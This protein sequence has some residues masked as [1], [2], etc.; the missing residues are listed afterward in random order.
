MVKAFGDVVRER[1]EKQKITLRKFADSVGMS[2]TYLSKIERGEFPP[3]A[4]EK[5]LAIAQRLE[6]DAD[7]LMSLAGRIPSDVAKI[8]RDNPVELSGFLRQAGGL[9]AQ[10]RQRL[11]KK[12]FGRTTRGDV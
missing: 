12:F 1:R 3:P 2:A 4:E 6:L 5:I 7:E 9:S 8:I 10:E 11:L